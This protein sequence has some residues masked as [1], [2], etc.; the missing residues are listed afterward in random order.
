MKNQLNVK[1]TNNEIVSLKFDESTDMV[2]SSD[3]ICSISYGYQGTVSGNLFFCK[4][5]LTN[6]TQNI[7]PTLSI[8]TFTGIITT[9]T[10][11]NE[12]E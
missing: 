12:L 6:T 9:L 8:T 5:L 10:V 1:I 4:N 2:N 3:L 11:N 7:F